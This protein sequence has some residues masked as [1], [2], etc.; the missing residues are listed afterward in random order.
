MGSAQICL[1]GPP[2]SPSAVSFLPDA[3][4]RA[5]RI[6]LICDLFHASSFSSHI[7]H[8]LR[9][10][11]VVALEMRFLEDELDI[12]EDPSFPDVVQSI[13][14]AITPTCKRVS[15]SSHGGRLPRTLP[16]P[17]RMSSPSQLTQWSTSKFRKLIDSVT[18]FR[19]SSV[20]SPVGPLWDTLSHFL[21]IS[22]IEI[23][24]LDCDISEDSWRILQS[25]AMPGLEMLNIVTHCHS[26][27]VFPTG[28]NKHHPK[29]KF[30]TMVNLRSW[31]TPDSLQL[32]TIHLSLPTLSHL[33]I[34]SNY[35]SFKIQDVVELSR[36]SIVSFM[37][38]PVPE[39]RGYCNVV[40]SLARTLRSSTSQHFSSSLTV[41]F[42]FPRFLDAH[43]RFCEENPVYQ[44]SCSEGS[45]VKNIRNIEVHADTLSE[46]FVVGSLAFNFFVYWLCMLQGYI[47]TWI[48]Q[49]PQVVH[50]NIFTDRLSISDQL[51]PLSSFRLY[52]QQLLDVTFCCSG[53]GP[54][55]LK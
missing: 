22:T 8:F 7:I 9:N 10:H 35:S 40:A 42:T 3:D 33:A 48:R 13:L 46:V 27:P 19:L 47:C 2:F 41:S 12:L 52:C 32:P 1:V 45:L 6:S 29:L 43:L 28:F 44:C 31:N 17:Y 37:T 30:L 4:L 34:T 36:L 26:P 54:L 50:L 38:L 14:S 39:N 15:F 49:F 23:V 20:F 55:S 21:Q 18:E 5:L 51:P 25:M 24:T 16:T 11:S 53:E